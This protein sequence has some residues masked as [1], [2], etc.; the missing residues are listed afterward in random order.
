MGFNSLALSD[1]S[2]FGVAPIVVG[3]QSPPTTL[4]PSAPPPSNPVPPSSLTLAPITGTASG[5]T[6]TFSG[7]SAA[8]VQA[9]MTDRGMGQYFSTTDPL[10]PVYDQ[11]V[12]LYAAKGPGNNATFIYGCLMAKTL[13]ARKKVNGDCGQSTSLSMPA[14]ATASKIGSTIVGTG[15]GIASGVSAAAGLGWA[16]AIGV[17]GGIATLALLPLG[18]FA[19]IAAHHAAAVAAEQTADCDAANFFNPYCQTVIQAVQNNTIGWQQ[20]K[21]YFD[22]ILATTINR[23]AKTSQTSPACNAGCQSQNAVKALHDLFVMLYGTAPQSAI[24]VPG[25]PANVAAGTL[26]NAAQSPGPT[27]VNAQS[28]AVAPSGAGLGQV[29]TVGVAGIGLHFVGA[30]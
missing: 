30:F 26:T 14:V 16:S 4:Q 23:L 18:I 11:L 6:C 8:M 2:F 7:S 22:Q 1:K 5:A 12:A 3:L 25:A 21:A 19:A 13:P 24:T 27:A 10:G 9:F 29:A 28:G 17:A 20:A 15:T